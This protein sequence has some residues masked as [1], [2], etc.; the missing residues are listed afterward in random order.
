ME[1]KERGIMGRVVEV[2][3]DERRGFHKI[4]PCLAHASK[5][6]EGFDWKAFE[7]VVNDFLGNKWRLPITYSHCTLHGVTWKGKEQISDLILQRREQSGWL[8]GQREVKD[9]MH[10]VRFKIGDE[11]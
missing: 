6:E 10:F 7:D 3:G 2:V 11:G 4:V 1:K 5:S 9:Y 8:C